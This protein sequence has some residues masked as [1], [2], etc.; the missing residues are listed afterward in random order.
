MALK[1]YKPI[2]PGLRFAA[3]LQYDVD[4]K[5]PE[6]KGRVGHPPHRQKQPSSRPTRQE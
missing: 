5:E 6:K 1:T 3:T 4:K 2:T